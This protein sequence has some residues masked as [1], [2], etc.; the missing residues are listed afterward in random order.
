MLMKKHGVI[1][2]YA[3]GDRE[4]QIDMDDYVKFMEQTVAE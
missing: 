1:I 4:G 3:S 2:S